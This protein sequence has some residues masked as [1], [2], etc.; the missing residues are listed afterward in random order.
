MERGF[1]LIE[2]LVTVAILG[3]LSSM[4][5]AAY[6][7]YKINAHNLE[8]ISFLA[9]GKVIITTIENDLESACVNCNQTSYSRCDS[10]PF[11]PLSCQNSNHTLSQTVEDLLPDK[12]GRLVFTI[13]VERRPMGPGGTSS[14][15]AIFTYHCDGDKQY[16]W[17]RYIG[18]AFDELGYDETYDKSEDLMSWNQY[19][20]S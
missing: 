12:I 1:T 5:I 17:I 13:N 2:L 20:N 4:S 8:A 14:Y 15:I 6:N 11:A 3:I 16:E 9:I 7:N 10:S 18:G 19:C